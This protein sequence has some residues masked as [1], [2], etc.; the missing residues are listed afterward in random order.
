MND[1]LAKILSRL[2]AP[3]D[4]F[5]WSSSVQNTAQSEEIRFR[6]EFAARDFGDYLRTIARHHSIPVMDREIEKFVGSLPPGAIVVDIGGGWGWHWRKLKSQ[7]KDITVVIVDFCRGNL[8]HARKLLG[9]PL[10]ESIILV[11]GDALQ[12]EFPSESFDAYWSVQSLQHIPD[13]EAAVRE[14]HRILR[15]NGCFATYSLNRAPLIQL[16]YR[17]FG[18]HY[19]IEGYIPGQSYFAR[20]S[21]RQKEIIGMVFCN[22]VRIRY[23][24]V[25]FHPDLRIFSGSQDCWV[26]RFDAL[27]S[28]ES[29]GLSWL[30]RQ[31]SF[32]TIKS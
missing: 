1:R 31:C 3:V 8:V 23:T 16:V 27:L 11:H 21:K 19:H 4:D 6:E 32:H 29:S 28:G 9:S 2:K 26:G 14:A 10:C 12:L 15:P 13:F 17:F 25:L 5:I 30:A 22:S 18:K 24:E 7:R 20:A